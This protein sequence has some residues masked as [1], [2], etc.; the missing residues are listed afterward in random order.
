VPNRVGASSEVARGTPALVD[1]MSTRK[2]WY[3]AFEDDGETGWFYAADCSS[4]P[5]TIRG[6]LF[7]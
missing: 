7:I 3:V 5:M 2:D 1:A 6:S 4:E